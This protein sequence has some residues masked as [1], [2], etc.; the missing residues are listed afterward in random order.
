MEVSKE[1]FRG[2]KG[3][4]WM[5]DDDT[6]T[7]DKPRAIEIAKACRSLKLRVVY[8]TRAHLDYETLK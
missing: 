7:I 4:E 8:A 2:A 1:P 3:A 6:F 5:F